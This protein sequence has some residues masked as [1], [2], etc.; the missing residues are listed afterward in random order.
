MKIRG[1][2]AKVARMVHEVPGWALTALTGAL[3]MLADVVVD[4]LAVLGVVLLNLGITGWS[5]ERTLLRAG[6]LVHVAVFLLVYDL[7]TISVTRGWTVE[8]PAGS[9]LP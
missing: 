7:K 3:M 1:K 2:S 5:G 4:P 9:G 8:R 6:I